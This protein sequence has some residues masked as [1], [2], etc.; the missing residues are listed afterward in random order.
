MWPNKYK[1]KIVV[2]A[3]NFNR[4]NVFLTIH[5]ATLSREICSLEWEF[6]QRRSFYKHSISSQKIF[7]QRH[8]NDDDGLTEVGR[9]A[10]DQT[11]RSTD[12]ESLKMIKLSIEQILRST[13]W[14]GSAK[15]RYSIKHQSIRTSSKSS[16]NTRSIIMIEMNMNTMETFSK[17]MSKE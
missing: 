13:D 4:A 11:S 10:G 16:G 2:L 8:S 7:S 9:Q 1:K 3:M 17:A 12:A 15:K 6:S 5:P 14:E